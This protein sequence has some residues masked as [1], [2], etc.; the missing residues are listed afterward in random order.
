MS[1]SGSLGV[2]QS[3]FAAFSVC[4]LGQVIDPVSFGFLICERICISS[5][6]DLTEWLSDYVRNV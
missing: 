1:S 6:T 3:W 5:V 4:D 2:G